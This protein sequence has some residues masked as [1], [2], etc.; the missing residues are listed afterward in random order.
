MSLAVGVD[1]READAEEVEARDASIR[2]RDA[3]STRIG[4]ALEGHKRAPA[5]R[6]TSIDAAQVGRGAAGTS[7][8]S[9]RN[10]AIYFDRGNASRPSAQGHRGGVRRRCARGRVELARVRPRVALNITTNVDCNLLESQGGVKIVIGGS[11]E[12]LDTKPPVAATNNQCSLSQFQGGENPVGTFVVIPDQGGGSSEAFEVLVVAGYQKS[13]SDCTA[14]AYAGCIVARRE[15]SFV[16][17]TPLTLPIAL[18]KE[19]VN[20]VC[21][22]SEW[23]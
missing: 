9:R 23:I 12:D 11:G 14:P 4:P 3:W 8:C 13:L 19:C 18:D 17:H 6:L 10:D 21:G 2:S 7:D 1:L 5:R 16:P 22:G 15:L 20:N